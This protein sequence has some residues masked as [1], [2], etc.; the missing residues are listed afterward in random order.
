MVKK[1]RFAVL[2]VGG[3]INGMNEHYTQIAY[4]GLLNDDDTLKFGVSLYVKVIGEVSAEQQNL[5]SEVADI[6]ARYYEKPLREYLQK[7]KK[8][9][10]KNDNQHLQS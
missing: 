5:M 8:E 9:Q 6:I 10:I 4:I 2:M 1:F 3:Q 7:L